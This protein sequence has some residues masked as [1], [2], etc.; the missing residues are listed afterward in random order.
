[1]EGK[2]SGR[3]RVWTGESRRGARELPTTRRDALHNEVT[4]RFV[5]GEPV[6]AWPCE[7][8]RDTAT[9]I[10]NTSNVVSLPVTAEV[11]HD[12]IFRAYETYERLSLRACFS[13]S[14]SLSPFQMHFVQ[15]FFSFFGDIFNKIFYY[16]VYVIMIFFNLCKSASIQSFLSCETRGSSFKNF[17]FLFFFF[18]RYL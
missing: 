18:L 4:K 5:G 14:H 3:K 10:E 1:M 12:S 9:L 11:R 13:L 2:R 15:F 6:V 17:F 8:A 7:T 16:Y